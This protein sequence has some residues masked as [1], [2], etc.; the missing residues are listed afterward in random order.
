MHVS[1]SS[2]HSAWCA[3]RV[4]HKTHWHTSRCHSTVWRWL[5]HTRAL[6]T[7]SMMCHEYRAGSWEHVYPTLYQFFNLP[8]LH[9][10][11][12]MSIE[13]VC[14]NMFIQH[15]IDFEIYHYYIHDVSWVYSWFVRTCIPNTILKMW[16]EP[17][18]NWVIA[19]WPN[20]RVV[21]CKY[22]V[23]QKQNGFNNK[24][25]WYS[26]LLNFIFKFTARL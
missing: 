22:Y 19:L 8:L 18:K 12:V 10:W 1:Q 2:P 5:W 9:P 6:A 20:T 24:I 26:I 25:H 11:C 17:P 14:E 21:K 23:S 13:L 15:Y 7:W 4:R 16:Y 3:H